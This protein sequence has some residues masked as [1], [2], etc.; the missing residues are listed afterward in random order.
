MDDHEAKEELETQE[1]DVGDGAPPPIAGSSCG[2]PS[3]IRSWIACGFGACAAHRSGGAARAVVRS[4]LA[5]VLV[6]V[7]VLVVILTVIQAII[8]MVATQGIR[9]TVWFQRRSGWRSSTGIQSTHQQER[10][11]RSEIAASSM[12]Q[13]RFHLR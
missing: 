1:E 2:N 3:P 8:Q 5:V 13:K 11:A 10:P 4:V 12:G 9:P 6:L 7:L